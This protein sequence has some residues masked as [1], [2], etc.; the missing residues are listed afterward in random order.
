MKNL[1]K[2]FLILYG[3]LNQSWATLYKVLSFSILFLL[4]MM[5]IAAYSTETMLEIKSFPLK[6]QTTN[7]ENM[8]LDFRFSPRR[9]QTCIGLPDDPHKSIVGSDGALYYGYGQS[10]GK[11]SFY[12]FARRIGVAL[13]TEYLPEPKSQSLLDATIPIVVTDQ[14]FNGKVYRL[15]QEVWAN[16]PPQGLTA[17]A[18]SDQRVD[19][20]WARVITNPRHKKA[21]RLVLQI[22]SNEELM[23][24]EQ[25][26]RV[27]SKKEPNR[28]I[29]DVA[30]SW[31]SA[32]VKLINGAYSYKLYFPRQNL[33]Q[34]KEYQVRVA[35][36]CGA[37]ASAEMSEAGFAESRQQAIAFWRSLKLPYDKISVPDSSVQNLFKSCVRNIFQAR[38]IKDDRLA[39][40]VG[41]T[42]YRG[43]WAV[44]GAFILE[45]VTY[46]GLVKEARP[47][48]ELQL[49]KVGGPG[50]VEFSKKAGIRLWA[51]WRHAQLTGDWDWLERVW[52]IVEREV[53]LIKHYRDMARQ[54]PDQVNY[55]LMPPGT[56]DGGL[57]GIHREYTNVYWNLAGLKA[58]VQ[59]ATKLQKSNLSDWQEEYRDFWQTF[60]R[61]RHRDKLVDEFGNTYVPVTMK[62]EE[63]QPPQRGAW[64]F[65]H[66]VFPGRVFS[67]DD[68]L[69]LGTLATL[70]AHQQEGL[71]FGTGWD[72]DGIWT[73]AG[74]FYGHAHLWLGHGRKAAATLYAFANHASP[75]LCWR[76]EQPVLWDKVVGYTGDMPHNWASAEFIRFIRHLLV[77]ERGDELHLFEGLPIT[78]TRP[79]DRVQLNEIATSFGDITLSLKVAD[80][81]RSALLRIV[82]P[83]RE[84]PGKIVVH[85]ENFAVPVKQVLLDGKPLS[86]EVPA[87]NTNQEVKIKLIF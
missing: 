29:C 28:I 47:G 15:H 64:A 7:L 54:D 81:G 40:Q 78:W 62:G 30:P 20:L 34:E 73:Y 17:P 61:A 23:L 53:N 56:G 79:G 12:G 84:K 5:T 65:L 42:C 21:S 38:E 49:E 26:G 13:E 9:W 55:G 57:G 46:L 3:S 27:V 51:I 60:D 1:S 77:L 85:T 25:N 43:T 63:P 72:K 35:V 6:G 36:H 70:D 45:A 32:E 24:I 44:D 83:K 14:Y 39:F 59:M 50:G 86:N 69:M 11:P 80:D 31:E 52:P 18:F 74:S 75:L 16:T 8:V 71:I 66:S 37:K 67:P 87:I 10:R 19:Y 82:P 76:E 58:A 4:S 33:Q 2:S 48:L 41:P 68:S 22:D